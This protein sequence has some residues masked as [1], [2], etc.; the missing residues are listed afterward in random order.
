MADSSMAGLFPRRSHVC[1]LI[2][3]E[4]ESAALI[5]L[6]I[7]DGS[8]RGEQVIAVAGGAWLDGL[9]RLLEAG[10]LGPA[11]SEAAGQLRLVPWN[12]I[13]P[14]SLARA[15]VGRALASVEQIVAGAAE[16]S[17]YA[18]V[19]ILE[20]MDWMV[21]ASGG[22][23]EVADYERGVDRMVKAYAQPAVCVYDLS[24]LSGQ[25]L[26]EILSTHRLAMTR[27]TLVESPF[28]NETAK[29]KP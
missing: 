16:D 17:R 7:R 5:P 13:Y 3:G 11:A 28:Y 9:R 21:S 15:G 10:D 27:G 24:R 4:E 8:D 1:A 29:G 22:S 14:A 18:G 25:L 12:Q 26:I 23:Q 6:F 2:E 20:Q 19:R